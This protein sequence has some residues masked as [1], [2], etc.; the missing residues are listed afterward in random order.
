MGGIRVFDCPDIGSSGSPR[1]DGVDFKRRYATRDGGWACVRGLK[2][3]ATFYSVALRRRRCIRLWSD[4]LMGA[5]R[6]KVRALALLAHRAGIGVDFKRRYAT[7]DLGWTCVR[8]LK[9]TATFIRSRCDEARVFDL[10]RR[11]YRSLCGEEES[12]RFR[13][14]GDIG[15]RATTEGSRAF[16]RPD[17]G[18]MKDCVAS[19]RLIAEEL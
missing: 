3:T 16:Q 17:I 5:G 13:T 8:G 9:P 15:R 2:P 12:V 10:I 6:V 14:Q 1:R 11:G 18:A 19:R 7:R 4:P